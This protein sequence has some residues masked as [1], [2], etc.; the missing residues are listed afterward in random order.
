MPCSPGSFHSSATSKCELCPEGEYQPLAGRTQCFACSPGT[1]TAGPGAVNEADCKTNCPPGHFFDLSTAS[2]SPCGAGYC[3]HLPDTCVF[4][5]LPTT[6]RLFRMYSVWHRQDYFVGQV[7]SRRTLQRRMSGR[8][9][10]VGGRLV[11]ALFCRNVQKTWR[12]QT[13]CQLSRWNN[14]RIRLVDTER[15]M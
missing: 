7:D 11:S 12:T 6:R 8:G 2:C 13:M 5:L 15:A 14:Y 3:N 10:V 1:V 4:Q 9:T